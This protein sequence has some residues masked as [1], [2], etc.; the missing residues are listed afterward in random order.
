MIR[1]SAFIAAAAIVLS[2]FLHVFGLS[3]TG[4]Q[5]TSSG[6]EPEAVETAALS[7][8]FED[9]A[10]SETQP[11]EPEAAEVPEPEPPVEPEP[12]PTPAEIPTSE[13]LVASENP[14]RVFAPDVG[15]SETI[16]PEVVEPAEAEAGPDEDIQSSA[17]QDATP[18]VEATEAIE[19]P[20]GQPEQSDPVTDTA[21]AQ[22][23]AAADIVAP[24]P[25]VPEARIAV[26]P[27]ETEAEPA[28]ETDAASELAVTASP[29]PQRPE[30]TSTDQPEGTAEAV[31]K[32]AELRNPTQ[33]IE[34]P[35][36]TYERRGVDRFT[37]R[38]GTAQS[39]GR[40]PGNSD[41]TN[42][43]GRVLVHLNRAPPVYAPSRGFAQVFFE[44]NP[45]GTLAWV[46]V[47]DSSGAADVNRAAKA[48]VQSA[49]PFPPPPGG[50][51]RK[52]SFYYRSN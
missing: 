17:E 10:E 20:Q 26:A 8:S 50:T 27:S 1:R 12:E 33:L 46:E 24:I 41:V 29:R 28:E 36:T 6:T 44:I 2:L 19:T 48:Q 49:S 15:I 13:A 4:P 32:F 30:P 22:Q 52:L 39:G 23:P 9:L 45:D 3:V 11:V 25:D 34:S 31:D 18:P 47:T 37:R 7:N 40:G 5:L 43:A 35:L 14:E 38:N 42:Y 51:S 21:E 16:E